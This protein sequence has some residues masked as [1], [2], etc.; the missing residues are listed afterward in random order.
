[1]GIRESSP[2]FS[3]IPVMCRCTCA[4][5]FVLSLSLFISF[6]LS[7]FLSLSLFLSFFRYLSL[8]FSFFLTLSLSCV[9]VVLYLNL[10]LCLFLFR[11]LSFFLL[12]V[13]IFMSLISLFL[14]FVRFRSIPPLGPSF[15]KVWSAADWR[16]AEVQVWR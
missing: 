15:D 10:Y 11:C 4:N 3:H 6:F 1:M 5:P 13:S 2:F 8:F 7:F 16:D 12:S 9:C 14:A